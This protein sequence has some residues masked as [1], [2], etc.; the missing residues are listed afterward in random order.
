MEVTEGG[1]V[2]RP[3]QNLEQ[4]SSQAEIQIERE[5]RAQEDGAPGGLLGRIARRRS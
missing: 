4:T 2:I 3:A 1:I 5:I